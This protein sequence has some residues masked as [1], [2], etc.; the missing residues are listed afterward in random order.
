MY[1]LNAILVISYR[2]LTKLLRDRTRIVASFIFPAIFIAVLGTSLQS[3]LSSAV[4]FNFLTFV[5]TGV[6]AQTLFQSTAAGIIS[7]IEDRQNDFSQEIFVS[8][9]SRYTIIIGKIVGESM[10]ALTQVIGILILGLLLGV[11]LSLFQLISLVPI[12]M[13]ACLFGGSFGIIIMAN[14]G[15]QRSANQV[16]PFIIFPQIFLSG[17]FNPIRN[18]PPV[19]YILSRISP[20][21]YVVDL[22]RGIYYLGRPEYSRVVLYQPIV[23]LTIITVFFLLFLFIGTYLFVRSERNR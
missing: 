22:T 1:S 10:V 7:L 2:D 20:M 16:F 9:V 23:D 12:M 11:S 18:L 5:F 13:I 6:L 17:V 21:T 14:L 8:P 3:N 4:G 15:S 19:I